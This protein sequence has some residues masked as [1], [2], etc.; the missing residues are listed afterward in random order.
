[1]KIFIT[2]GSGLLADSS[3]IVRAINVKP[4]EDEKIPL[5]TTVIRS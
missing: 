2:G 1:M 4:E 3:S 5:I